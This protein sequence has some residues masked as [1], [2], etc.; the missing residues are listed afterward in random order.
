[1][2]AYRPAYGRTREDHARQCIF[3]ATTNEQ[4][5]LKGYNGNRRFWVVPCKAEHSKS[6]FDIDDET[7]NQI[8]AEAVEIY[9]NGEPLFLSKELEKEM[10]NR[11]EEYNELSQDVRIGMIQD[12]LDKKL[13]PDWTQMSADQK[14]VYLADEE[15]IEQR[16]TYLRDKV[17]VA[18][19]LVE[20][21]HERI[22]E[23]MRYRANEIT[24]LLSRIKGWERYPKAMRFEG[25]GTQKGFIRIK[26]D[27]A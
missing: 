13:P 8:W 5:F 24:S 23:K 6:A 22:D 4:A 11:Q 19:V 16:G 18:E 10:R 25:Y 21:L 1:V 15:A 9:K 26:D 17:C 27:K 14:V 7:R 3:F 12:F 2:D 20:C